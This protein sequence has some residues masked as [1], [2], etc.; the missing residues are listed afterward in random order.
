MK[1][2]IVSLLMT[3][4][5]AA[6]LVACGSTD[7]ADTT[8]E[9]STATT[10]ATAEASGDVAVPEKLTIM[11]SGDLA[12]TQEEGQEAFVSKLQE[13]TGIGSID[14]IQP[15][16]SAYY[17]V[18]GTTMASGNIPDCVYLGS[19]Y[20]ASYASEGILWDM[21]DAYEASDLK[22]RH[23]AKGSGQ[24]VDAVRVDGRLYGMPAWKGGGCVTYVR[25]SWLDAAELEV[26][27]TYDE[28]I[29]ML[30]KFKEL[31]LGN[32]SDYVIGAAG[33]IGGEAPFIN[34]WPEFYQDAYPTFVKQA[35]GTW[36]DGFTQDSMK[37]ALQ[38]MTDAVDAGLIDLQSLDQS[39][40]DARTKFMAGD[41]GAFTYWANH[42]AKNLSKGM[43][44]GEDP[45]LVPL[46]PIKEVGQYINRL[47]PVWCITAA[48]QN[49]EGAFKYFI[50]TMQDGG[51]VQFLWTYG[52]EGYHYSYAAESIT[53]GDETKEYQEG[54]FH[55]LPTKADPTK[56]Y[57]K[58]HITAVDTL[59]DLQDDPNPLAEEAVKAA[60]VFSAN[61]KNEELT[62]N[63]DEYAEMNGDLT[64]LKNE[65]IA[66]VVTG[67]ISIDDA[68]AQFE[69]DPSG[70]AY[71]DAIVESLNAL[72]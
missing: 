40:K 29:A 55:W 9:G 70:Q 23:D 15:D 19:T 22:A 11:V 25:Q 45:T 16:H 67:Q 38:R 47:S 54:E 37:A 68:Y 21:T 39:T 30:T 33:F 52:A 24:Y 66:K 13:L 3:A 7:S 6:S 41:Y 5:M 34:Y 53:L 35:D 20:Y 4:V 59:V 43:P 49:P 44:E 60:E 8:T 61:C 17:D 2:R 57:S 72:Q 64:T 26:P 12:A 62:P 56:A 27:T 28:Y 1:K 69:S 42:W 63:T 14:I 50:E 51:E 48:C 71:S 10:E 65:L 36:I 46:P 31:G 18:L 58:I 32:V